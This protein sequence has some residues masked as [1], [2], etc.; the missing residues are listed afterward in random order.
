L[1]ISEY[2]Q[3][4]LK[5]LKRNHHNI[6]IDQYCLYQANGRHL[7]PAMRA[8]SSVLDITLPTAT[9]KEHKCP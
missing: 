8:I 2:F 6:I 7:L 3:R 5:L 1:F 9:A 4:S